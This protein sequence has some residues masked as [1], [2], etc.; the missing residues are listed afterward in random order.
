[1]TL[2]EKSLIKKISI[3]RVFVDRKILPMSKI[4]LLRQ[5]ET[6]NYPTTN[7]K[8]I[9]VKDAQQKPRVKMKLF[10]E[11]SF[12]QF[13]NI[14]FFDKLHSFLDINKKKTITKSK[15]KS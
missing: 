15:L 3:I 12:F 11:N 2:Q 10:R 1:M 13:F 7:E 4:F 14:T 8:Q 9:K 5:S 6:T